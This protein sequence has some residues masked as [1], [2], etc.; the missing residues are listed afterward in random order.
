MQS[1]QPP[2]AENDPRHAIVQHGD[3]RRQ[4]SRQHQTPQ[5]LLDK[6]SHL[7]TLMRTVSEGLRYSI[8]GRPQPRYVHVTHK[9]SEALA[10]KGILRRVQDTS[11]FGVADQYGLLHVVEPECR[12]CH[13]GLG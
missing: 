6:V 7:L 2:V 10:C 5:Q 13:H 9:F 4:D 1:L 8:V 3:E 12:P 11:L